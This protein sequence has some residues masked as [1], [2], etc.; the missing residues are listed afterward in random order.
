MEGRGGAGRGGGKGNKGRN[1]RT[2]DGERG[3]EEGEGE[4]HG[5]REESKERTLGTYSTVLTS[6]QFVWPLNSIEVNSFYFDVR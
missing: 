5:E 3:W 4:E 6:A 2:G 1:K